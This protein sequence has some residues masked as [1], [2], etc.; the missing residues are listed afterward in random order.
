MFGD[1]HNFNKYVET[2]GGY[3]F[4]PR[5][6]FGEYSLYSSES[7]FRQKLLALAQGV[8]ID[9]SN[10]PE[11]EFKSPNIDKV[12]LEVNKIF[13][14]KYEALDSGLSRENLESIGATISILTWLGVVDLHDDNILFGR[15]DRGDFIF[16]PVDLECIFFGDD[17]LG[18][19]LLP[20]HS[21]NCGCE[22]EYCMKFG[23]SSVFKHILRYND[24]KELSRKIIPSILKGFESF[25]KVLFAKKDELKADLFRGVRV[26]SLISRVILLNTGKYMRYLEG[27]E[28]EEVLLEEERVQLRRGDIPYFFKF[29]NDDR[30]YYWSSKNKY[31]DI[32]N[33]SVL[34]S[35]TK[36][37]YTKLWH[38]NLE[39]NFENMFVLLIIFLD[40][41]PDK[42]YKV[43]LEDSLVLYK[44]RG[45]I[46][47]NRGIRYCY[48]RT[49]FKLGIKLNT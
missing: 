9:L 40:M 3:V 38:E 45:L 41:Y 23:L 35:R 27:N 19:D 28:I 34:G 49:P 8:G 47:F 4:K 37:D 15:S 5:P 7:I 36:Q 18:R 10:L 32:K 29:Y 42:N 17:F 1:K 44:A 21:F 25:S 39:K 30:V 26:E 33:H 46:L 11:V 43:Q 20:S 48:K 22:T 13:Q 12:S 2:K 6:V 14:I 24:K 16:A 31:K